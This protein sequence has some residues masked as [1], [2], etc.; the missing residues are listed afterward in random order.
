MQLCL[1]EQTQIV[2]NAA[3]RMGSQQ[4]PSWIAN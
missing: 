2:T 3:C 1:H 4:L